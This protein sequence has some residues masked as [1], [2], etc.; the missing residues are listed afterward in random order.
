VL[1]LYRPW[2]ELR[3]D[4]FFAWGTLG[5]AVSLPLCFRVGELL[6]LNVYFPPTAFMSTVSWWF[7]FWIIHAV[8]FLLAGILIGLALMNAGEDAHK[9]YACNLA[10]SAAGAL[11][12]IALMWYFPANGLVVPFSLTILMGGLFLIQPARFSWA[13]VCAVCIAGASL[14]IAGLFPTEKAFPLNVDQYKSLAYVQRLVAQGTAEAKT[15][16]YGPR[17]RVDLF[18]SPSFHTVMSLTATEPPPA[19]DLVLIDGF[20]A[21]SIPVIAGL[22]QA[23]FLERTLSALPYSLIR[24]KKVLI[25]G[26]TGGVCAWLA[27]MSEA[28]AIVFVQPDENIIRVLQDH[29]SRVLDDPRIRIVAAEPRAFLDQT[30]DTF[31]IIHL[32]ALEGFSAGSGGI[33]GLREDYLA[34]VAGF[35]KVLE[36]LTPVGLASVA[37]GIQ[38]PER[39]NIKIAATWI[40]ALEQQSQQ[41]GNHMLVARDEL[42]LATLVRKSMIPPDLTAE[43][44]NVLKVRSWD[45]EW[46]PGVSPDSTN[47][48]HI[49]PGPP[50][51]PMS[52]YQHAMRMLL[53]PQRQEFYRNWICNVRPATDDKPFF[54]DFFR[55]GSI[56]RLREA[57]GPLWPARA[58]MGFLVL[59]L[60]TAWTLIAASVLLPG[61]ILRMKREQ[62]TPSA[63]S[64][65]YVAAYFAGLGTGFM[66]LEMSFIQMFTRF[67]GDP[68]VAA[69]VV[70]GC[71][72]LFAGMGSMSQPFVIGLVPGGVLTPIALIVTL[73]LVDATLFPRVFEAAALLPTPW[74]VLAGVCMIAPLAFFLGTPFPWGLSVLHR[75]AAKAIPIAWAVNGFASVVSASA[76]VV[77]AMTFGFKMLL[78]L[79]AFAYGVSGLVSLYLGRIADDQTKSV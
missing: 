49:L 13:Y 72:L 4:H 7:L 23:V 3:A 76:A 61:P 41:P 63:T 31:D 10:G 5:F 35:R 34:T 8:P 27:R 25:L 55:W 62:A 37:R 26:D 67:L 48:L 44:R 60:A 24:P 64:L 45:V 59:M 9:V 1:G 70:V 19:M 77:L 73:T 17:G 20:Q 11:G 54:Y 28:E 47:R 65:A 75:S 57:F 33:G 38:E 6:P 22:G 58:E 50:E 68:V 2:F 32:A 43:F 46:F 53:S 52:W 15:S 16:Y 21:G 39:D 36:R 30:K 71:F 78:S 12:A 14:F 42:S 18:S 29:P 79:A 74:K 40:E 56:S 66:L 69:A 51:T